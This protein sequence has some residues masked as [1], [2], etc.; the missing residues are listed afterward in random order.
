MDADRNLLFGVLALQ[1]DLIDQRQFAEACTDWSTRKQTPLADILVEQGWLG[2]DDRADVDKLLQRK[3][4]KHKGD[5][6]AGLTEVTTDPV[7]QSLAGVA[8]AA[9]QQSLAGVTTPPAGLVLEATTAPAVEQR[10]RYTLSRLHATGGIGRVWLARDAS[11]ARDVALKELRP[12]RAANPAVSARFLRE[13][14]ITGQLEHPGIV[15]IYEV[16]QRPEDQTPFYTMRFVRGRTLAEAARAYHERRRRGEAGPLELRQLLGDFVGVCH[17]VAYAHSRGVL[18]RDLKPSNVVLGDY[19]EVIVLDWGLARLLAETEAD[20]APLEVP[21][22]SDLAQTIQGQVLGTPAYM[23]PE[24][25]EGRLDQLGPPTDVYGLG[26]VLYEVL[27]GRPP[28]RSDES[29]ALLRQVVHETPARPRSLVPSIPAALE[30]VCLKALAKKARERYPTAKELAGEVQHWLADE[31]VSACREPV[32]ARLARWS[33]RHRPLVVGALAVAA[34]VVVALAIGTVLLGRANARIEQES[35]EAQRQ[36]DLANE[37]AQKARRAVN[38][39]FTTVSENTLLKS[40]LPGLQPLRKELLQSA[41]TYYQDFVQQHGDDPALRSDLAAAY[42]RVGKMTVQIGSK[43]EGLNTHQKA[44][45]LYRELARDEPGNFA[46]QRG[47]AMSLDRVANAQW[48][49][50]RTAEALQTYR[51]ALAVAEPLAREHRDDAELQF[52]LAGTYKDLG[53]VQSFSSDPRGASESYERARTILE[54]LTAQKPRE[55]KY[56]SLLAGVHTGIGDLQVLGLSQFTQALRSYQDAVVI[57]EKLAQE[58]PNDVQVQHHLA[59]HHRG[60]A[61]ACFYLKRWDSCLDENRKSVAILEK[62]ARENPRVT[63]YQSHLAQMYVNLGQVLNMLNSVD[64]SLEVA[65]KAIDGM[66]RSLRES[67]NETE[68]HYTLAQALQL[69]G[70]NLIVQARYQEVATALE[71]AVLHQRRAVEKAPDILHYSRELGT[72]YLNLGR[73]QSR[74]GQTARARASWQQ[75]AQV[76]EGY[77]TAHPKNV[78]YRH[79][80]VGKLE[81]VAQAERAAGLVDDALATRRRALAIAEGLVREQPD[82][83]QFHAARAQAATIVGASLLAD[84]GDARGALVEHEKALASWQKL[85]DANPKVPGYQHALA[86][87]HTAVADA[88]RTLGR[89]DEAR[90][91][92]ERAIPL[93]EALVKRYPAV[94]PYQSGLASN[95]SRLGITHQ[96]A[97]RPADA[98]KAHQG[99]IKVMEDLR[100]PSSGNLYSLACY[101]ALLAGVAGEAGSGLTSDEA[102]TMADRAM[103]RLSAA[104]AAGFRNVAHLRKDTDLDSLRK[105]DDFQKLLADLDARVKAGAP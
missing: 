76:W 3:L 6:R 65:R 89:L 92:Y 42:L 34:A 45:A 4:K 14:R 97:G 11:L 1:A 62:L 64:E 30:A 27:T 88:L 98:V 96:R 2:V 20:T 94:V 29:T 32:T 19:G 15:P 66:E 8:D 55:R 87:S 36:R 33:R 24:Q 51:Q 103:L 49:A 82:S 85:A 54:R 91:N 81:G 58:D 52:D 90:T 47:L 22:S 41:L 69:R 39:Y 72:H 74:L 102:R 70:Q 10:D 57:Q 37:N 71:Q 46:V 9:V 38:D 78:G 18:H 61:T 44:L 99:A 63:V 93:R 28:F 50:D 80:L 31:P 59:M 60:I 16:G 13:A 43:E 26:A 48:R 77:A 79:G 95:L 12:E 25:A 53:S 56:R 73:A 21:A 100:P 68:Y 75:A 17:A 67:P 101:Q 83:L 105:R 23:A 104:V 40:P 86:S 35:A 84:R 7:R 5:A